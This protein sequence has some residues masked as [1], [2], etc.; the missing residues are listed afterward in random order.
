MTWL[1][2]IWT[3]EAAPGVLRTVLRLE[4]VQTGRWRGF[5]SAE[6]LVNFLI[7]NTQKAMTEFDEDAHSL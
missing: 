3:V 5:I 7:T 4:D 6:K 1:L 2:R